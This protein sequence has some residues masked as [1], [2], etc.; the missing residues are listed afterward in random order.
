VGALGC[1]L[2][3]GIIDAVMYLTGTRGEGRLAAS[4]LRAIQGLKIPLSVGQ[5][6]PTVFRRSFFRR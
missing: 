1:N 3:W 6:S 5:S 4:T 2:A